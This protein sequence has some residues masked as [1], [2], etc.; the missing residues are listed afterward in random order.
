MEVRWWKLYCEAEVTHV[1]TSI[2]GEMEEKK[3]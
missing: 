2:A 1:P 3:N